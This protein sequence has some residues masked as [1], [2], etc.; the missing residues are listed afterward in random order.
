MDDV[1]RR[2]S[3]SARAG[4]LFAVRNKVALHKVAL[5]EPAFPL[6]V[7]SVG[8]LAVFAPPF[9]PGC[10]RPESKEQR[11]PTLSLV[12]LAKT[13]QKHL[14]HSRSHTTPASSSCH[15]HKSPPEHVKLQRATAHLFWGN[16]CQGICR[17]F[18]DDR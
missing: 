9:W 14:V 18:E 7:G 5:E 15:S 4:R 16:I 2:V 13:L 3:I 12:G 17:A 11:A 6:S 8:F 10:A 1:G